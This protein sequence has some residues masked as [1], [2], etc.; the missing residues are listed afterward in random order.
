M[1]H[2]IEDDDDGKAVRTSS[3]APREKSKCA[4]VRCEKKWVPSVNP[5]SYKHAYA[6]FKALCLVTLDGS[7]ISEGRNC[8][9]LAHRFEC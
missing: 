5:S 4:F 8:L 2:Q 3:F 7:V 6:A 9:G 1:L